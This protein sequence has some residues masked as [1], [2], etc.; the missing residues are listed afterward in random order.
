MSEELHSLATAVQRNCDISDAHHARNYTLCIYLL[1]MREYFRWEKGYGF[2]DSLPNSELGDWL[3]AREQ[4]WQEL[5]GADFAPIPV[6]G[7]HYQPFEA[8][9]IN[10]RLV[11]RGLVYSGGIGGFARAHFFLAKLHR[12]ERRDGREILIA[13]DEFAR[14]LTAPPAMSLGDTIFV[15]R[16]S[17]RRMLWEK[18]EEWRWNEGESPMSRAMTFYPFGEDLDTA[19]DA[20]TEVELDAVVL[21]EM[22]ETR[23]GAILGSQWER[24]L[25]ATLQSRSELVL[26]AVRDHLAD[27]AVTLP[28]LLLEE[29]APSLHF[30]FANLGGMRKEIFPSLVEA[31]RVWCENGDLGVMRRIVGEGERHWQA[32]AEVLAELPTENEAGL[33]RAIEEKLESAAL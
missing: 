20:M 16:Q 11:P 28:H 13:G 29:R 9:R 22:G 27:C 7:A 32:L 26:R 21:H 4:L 8:D 12:H 19:L 30:Y 15:R 5:E 14:D 1:K 31:Y 10:R 2:A 18:V 6:D 25:E 17:I 33:K 24:M 23:A 3:T